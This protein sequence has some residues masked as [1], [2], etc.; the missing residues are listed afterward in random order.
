MPS[1]DSTRTW[2]LLPNGKA[3]SVYRCS[4]YLSLQ[5]S[6]Q[7]SLG[8]YSS[9]VSWPRTLADL[10]FAVVDSG[11]TTI[12]EPANLQ[13]RLDVMA[14]PGV[15]ARAF[16]CVV[17]ASDLDLLR[18]RSLYLRMSELWERMFPAQ[19]PVVPN[20]AAQKG[21]LFRRFGKLEPPQVDIAKTFDSRAY[22]QRALAPHKEALQATVRRRSL[23]LNLPTRAPVLLGDTPTPSDFLTDV[24]P[25]SQRHTDDPEFHKRML[26]AGAFPLLWRQLGLIIDF[27]FTTSA[28]LTDVRLNVSGGSGEDRYASTLLSA[29]GSFTAQLDA[30]DTYAAGY[31]RWDN[32]FSL[33]NIDP[34]AHDVRDDGKIY[35]S[36]LAAHW[37]GLA[38][39]ANDRLAAASMDRETLIS[40]AVP[41]LGY[42]DLVR[43]YR[44]DIKDVTADAPW[45]SLCRRSVTY[46][47]ARKL[48]LDESSATDRDDEGWIGISAATSA[49]SGDSLVHD[50]IFRWDGH[51]LVTTRFPDDSSPTENA[52]FAARIEVP[53]A[54]LPALRY[55]HQYKVRMRVADMAGNGLPYTDTDESG[56]ASAFTYARY[57]QYD[58][59][60]IVFD[61]R[62]PDGEKSNTLILRKYTDGSDYY[63][64]RHLLPPAMTYLLAERHGVVDGRSDHQSH[65]IAQRSAASHPQATVMGATMPY[66][67]DPSV[68]GVFLQLL[69]AADPSKALAPALTCNYP[70]TW[71]DYGPVTV[72]VVSGSGPPTM[73][74]SENEVTIALQPAD[75]ATLRVS[76]TVDVKLVKSTSAHYLTPD[77]TNDNRDQFLADIAVGVSPYAPKTD[78]PIVHAVQQPSVAPSFPT[79]FVLAQTLGSTSATL[80][81]TV[82]MDVR[83]TGGLELEAIWTDVQDLDGPHKPPVTLTSKRVVFQ[84]KR[85][86]GFMSTDG[87]N[88][89]LPAIVHAFGDHRTH[90]VHYYW[91]A[92]SRFASDFKNVP[93][94]VQTSRKEPITVRALATLAPP[95][96]DISEVNPAFRYVDPS[97]KSVFAYPTCYGRNSRIR[98][99]HVIGIRLRRPWFVTG[100][101]EQLAVVCLPENSLTSPATP[102]LTPAENDPLL[103]FISRIGRDPTIAD[104][105]NQPAIA[106]GKSAFGATKAA[107]AV[108]YSMIFPIDPKKTV[109]LELIPFDVEFNS[110]DN[111]WYA[112]IELQELSYRPFVQFAIARYQPYALRGI[113]LSPIVLLPFMP[114]LPTRALSW[115]FGFPFPNQIGITVTGNFFSSIS[116]VDVIVQKRD[117]SAGAAGELA[118]LDVGHTTASR[119]VTTRGTIEYGAIVDLPDPVSEHRV[120]TLET[121]RREADARINTDDGSVRIIPVPLDKDGTQKTRSPVYM[122]LLNVF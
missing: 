65:R 33:A 38:A 88:V 75:S 79:A 96:P 57:D 82:A 32:R 24:A 14:E 86:Q 52:G 41:K 83:T 67:P 71:P 49:S 107:A 28:L 13:H 48:T 70:G 98:S 59:P 100:E 50:A 5:L 76:S 60:G 106:L 95:A 3:G 39:H 103:P 1:L 12:A 77:L 110:E 111:S 36:G 61:R 55:G 72:T 8:S 99:Q 113:G 84:A 90:K 30:S 56:A 92:R 45:R 104:S 43:G 80:P 51:S 27:T 118:W 73:T 47:F 117:H 94:A 114:M 69:D 6:R 21:L 120:I 63:I 22:I 108:L 93:T 11:G 10:R 116:N 40:G 81:Q 85:D 87:I 78:L 19:L 109:H 18:G 121:E 122:D 119:I 7:A 68:N 26:A 15:L 31:L 20:G 101:G 42:T 66:I 37:G 16:P 89:A 102:A 74:A 2:T 64:R 53:A 9:Y 115:S 25:A 23:L 62:V 34:V 29:D 44:V 54:S 17:Y 35:T 46:K 105:Y 112:F 97:D 4:A 91:T 58:A